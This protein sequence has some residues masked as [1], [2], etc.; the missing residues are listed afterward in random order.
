MP[1]PYLTQY[2]FA[3][4]FIKT[5]T[6]EFPLFNPLLTKS[7]N[8][9]YKLDFIHSTST[10][11]PDVNS[12]NGLIPHD[13]RGVEDSSL[14]PTGSFAGS[15]S[16]MP[17]RSKSIINTPTWPCCYDHFFSF[18]EIVHFWLLIVIALAVVSCPK[19]WHSEL[20]LPWNL[21]SNCQRSETFEWFI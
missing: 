18:F 8:Y 4:K 15:R 21:F 10:M 20:K 6:V 1:H 19:L 7:R 16:V 13:S 11:Q 5:C 12:Y 9:T 3:L 17:G 14:S 2:C